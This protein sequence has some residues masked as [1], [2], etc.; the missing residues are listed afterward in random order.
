[1]HLGKEDLKGACQALLE[2][3]EALVSWKWDKRF[4]SLVSVFETEGA[5]EVRSIIERHLDQVWDHKSIRKA[6]APVQ[7]GLDGFGDLRKGQ[8]FFTSDPDQQPLVVGAWWPWGDQSA[9][10][11]RLASPSDEAGE[12]AAPGIFARIRGLFG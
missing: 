11:L 4:E 1:M 6:P 3:S 9:V 2:D 12:A 5:D 10:S 8:L 7:T